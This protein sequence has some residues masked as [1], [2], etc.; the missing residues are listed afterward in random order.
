M[1]EILEET[2]EVVAMDTCKGLFIIYLDMGGYAQT[3]F[4]CCDG[5][6]MLLATTARFCPNCGGMISAGDPLK[7]EGKVA[8][9]VNI[10]D[11]GWEIVGD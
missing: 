4:R 1:S 2:A 8:Y 10:P 6:Y 11:V 7:V 5:T 3:R 9:Q